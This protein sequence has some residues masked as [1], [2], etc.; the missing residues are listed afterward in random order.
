MCCM[1]HA[2]LY[3]WLKHH[4]HYHHLGPSRV[5]YG[6]TTLCGML[7]HH[8]GGG[9]LGHCAIIGLHGYFGLMGHCAKRDV[10]Q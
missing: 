10:G 5:Q 7:R 3:G 4:V 8:A 6:N 9:L 1:T 2:L